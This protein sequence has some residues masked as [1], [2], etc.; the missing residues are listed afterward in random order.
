MVNCRSRSSFGFATVACIAVLL[1]GTDAIAQN[2]WSTTGSLSV[3]RQDHTA[4]LLSDGRV[5]VAGGMNL[6]LG[7]PDDLI[8]EVLRSAEVYDP[9]SGTWSP[10]GD[11]ANVRTEHSATLLLDGRVLIAGGWES[12]QQFEEPKQAEIFDPITGTWSLTDYLSIS[13]YRSQ[14]TATRLPDGRVLLVG[15]VNRN[16]TVMDSAEV[17]DPSAG[18]FTPTGNLQQGRRQHTATLLPDGRVLVA[19]GVGNPEFPMQGAEI[20]DPSTGTWSAT[21]SMAT[22]RYYHTATLL[23]NGEVLVAGGGRIAVL[24]SGHEAFADVEVYDPST[25][26]WTP[27]TSMATPRAAHTATQLP[28]G[29]LLIVGRDSTAE[30]FDPAGH[31]SST[32]TLSEGNRR[33]HTATLLRDGRVLVAGGSV[34]EVF[35]ARSLHTGLATAELYGSLPPVNTWSPA[36]SMADARSGRTAFMQADGHTATRLPDGKVLVAGGD[37]AALG[38]AELFDPSTG[39]WSATGSMAEARSGHAATL[40]ADGRVLVTGGANSS[41]CF[42]TAEVY[43]PASG[44]WSFTGSMATSR[45]GHTAT[46]LPDGRVLVAGG[47]PIAGPLSSSDVFLASAEV[48]DPSTGTWSSTG[49]MSNA[50]FAHTATLL[51]DGQVLASGGAAVHGIAGFGGPRSADLYDPATGLWSPTAEPRRSRFAHTATLLADGRVLTV[52]G[53]SA[54]DSA[55]IYDPSTR[56]W[57]LTGSPTARRWLHSAAWLP[58]G[59]VLVAGGYVFVP[60]PSDWISTASAEV[61]DPS[62]GSWS[63]IDNMTTPRTYPTMTPL[64][65]GRILVAGGYNDRRFMGGLTFLSSVEIFNPPPLPSLSIDNALAIEGA[66]VALFTVTLSAATTQSVTVTVMATDGTATAGVDFEG[67]VGTLTFSPGFTSQQ[68]AVEFAH[69]DEVEGNETFFV[70]LS[71]ATNA[72]ITDAQ[73]L[74]TIVDDDG[75]LLTVQSASTPAGTNVSVSLPP[76]ALTFDEVTEAGDTALTMGPTGPQTPAGFQLGEP[77]TYIEL[78]TSAEFTGSVEVC[79]NYSGVSFSNESLIRLFHFVNATWTDITTSV[80]TVANVICGATTSF[81]PFAVLQPTTASAPVLTL[82]SD[83]TAEATSAAGAAVAYTATATDGIG[84]PLPVVCSSLSGSTFALGA[85]TVSC[86]ATE[87][88]GHSASGSFVV[89]VVD[90]TPPALTL[91]PGITTSAT[92]TA[93]AVVSFTTSASDLVDGSVAVTCAPASGSTFPVGTATVAC[94]ATDSHTNVANGSF[95]VSVSLA[96]TINKVPKVLGLLN[97]TVRATSAAGAAV[98]F[99]VFGLDREDGLLPAVCSHQSGSVFPIGLTIVTCTTTDSDGAIGTGQFAVKVIT[100]TPPKVRGAVGT[101]RSAI[102]AK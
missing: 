87:G 12:N 8:F 19:G 81:S 21:G 86:S 16:G 102:E 54:S 11:M 24:P 94:S 65:D 20:Y 92:S 51:P 61:F 76:I 35:D 2:T 68:L 71:N 60:P 75:P 34:D 93:G 13:G 89:T 5:L 4:T 39:G 55:E 30:V 97:R 85:T 48:Y 66:G 22:G 47:D 52:G 84:S 10:T 28:F 95:T 41:T 18:V 15:G 62:T 88:G 70:T 23:P 33:G 26:E 80:D 64:P 56:T 77:P 57:S 67:I 37:H 83:I 99:I 9:S 50:R 3:A 58:D 90:T 53:T 36:F 69:D 1:G 40:L 29:S 45:Y 46:L 25:G 44:T 32:G 14:H 42:A 78:L 73:G 27:R 7:E 38:R 63:S 49:S 31:W 96:T 100:K 17:Y 72:A 101:G 6:N 98:R 59:R 82:P 79:V 91:P 74:A 43:D